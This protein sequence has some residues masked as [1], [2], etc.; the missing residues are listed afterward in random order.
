[1]SASHRPPD[2]EYHPV[3]TEESLPL[4]DE[5]VEEQDDWE[6]VEEEGSKVTC[7]GATAVVTGSWRAALLLALAL[8]T[9]L[10]ALVI[11]GGL[12]A[13][14]WGLLRWWR[15]PQ[16]PP[17]SAE[18]PFGCS[19]AQSLLPPHPHSFLSSLHS[20]SL[21][22]CQPPPLSYPLSD[23]LP[24]CFVASLHALGYA[25]DPLPQCS[26]LS[27]NLTLNLLH[28]VRY[29]QQP[30]VLADCSD[31]SPDSLHCVVGGRPFTPQWLY[32]SVD[33]LDSGA[34]GYADRLKGVLSTFLLA[35]LTE[36][37]FAIDNERPLSWSDF[38]QPSVL[39]WLSFSQLDPT[40]VHPTTGPPPLD[41]NFMGEDMGT[42]NDHDFVKDWT[43]HPIVRMRHNSNTVV[44]SLNNPHLRPR[45]FNMSLDRTAAGDLDLY[46]A[47]FLDFLFKPSPAL[48]DTINAVM[49][50]VGRPLVSSGRPAAAA[51]D[52]VSF[53]TSPPPSIPLYC[54][55]IRQG[56]TGATR[57]FQDSEEF[58]SSAALTNVMSALR[59]KV[60]ELSPNNASYFLFITSDTV[61]YQPLVSSFFPSP[62]ATVVTIEG[63]PFHLDKPNGE[64]KDSLLAE[65]TIRTSYLMTIAS[66]TLLGECDVVFISRSG[67]GALSQWR[68]RLVKNLARQRRRKEEGQVRVDTGRQ[69]DY[70][71]VWFIENGDG[72]LVEYHHDRGSSGREQEGAQGFRDYQPAPLCSAAA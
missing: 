9:A 27:T 19:T 72:R 61:D 14:Q 31:Y 54:A 11:V 1:M 63:K 62:P 2:A 38:W 52:A 37:A 50:R 68:T 67:F 23:A 71:H 7:L 42:L 28:Y 18:P 10:I 35:V 36:R 32:F 53:Y 59:A 39:P 40:L 49:R 15:W 60:D 66:F 56:N 6:V 17:L 12:V 51:R 48:A 47:C 64:T 30:H 13:V 4:S 21:S 3:L 16:L 57:T 20:P 33:H 25:D 44:H 22:Q 26:L 70:A 46:L 34:G 43:G 45:A 65:Q 24:P 55:Q 58:V 69:D 8:W 29:V 41:L 5:E